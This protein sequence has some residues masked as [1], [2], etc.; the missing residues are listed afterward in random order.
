LLIVPLV[1]ERGW[2][3]RRGPAG[4][5]SWEPS[6]PSRLR[7]GLTNPSSCAVQQQSR[8]HCLQGRAL[9]ALRQLRVELSGCVLRRMSPSAFLGATS[10]RFA[11]C[12]PQLSPPCASHET[13]VQGC[14]AGRG[15]APSLTLL[16]DCASLQVLVPN[17]LSQS[18]IHGWHSTPSPPTHPPVLCL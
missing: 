15:I 6:W 1:K 5:A 2:Y 17:L 13:W 4:A 9:T 18:P 14:S 12:A 11:E 16:A 7:D 10:F 8:Q 3:H